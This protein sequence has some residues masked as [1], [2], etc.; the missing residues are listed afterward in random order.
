MSDGVVYKAVITSDSDTKEYIGSCSTSFKLRYGNHKNSFVN[1]KKKNDTELS[2]Y[3]WQLKNLNKSF[4]I[5]WKIITK[6]KCYSK[7]SLNCKLCLTEKMYILTSDK[8]KTINNR[9]LILK[10][11]HKNKFKLNKLIAE[12]S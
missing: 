10:C 6:C 2:N 8:I 12:N 3:I 7:G 11:H 5:D 9:E 4:K 1:L